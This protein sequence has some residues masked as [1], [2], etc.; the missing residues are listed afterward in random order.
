[1]EARL[2]ET[3]IKETIPLWLAVAITVVVS[4]PFG[5]YLDKYNLP[6]WV[7]FVV[8]AQYFALGAKPQALRLIVPAFVLGVAVT[9]VIMVAVAVLAP[10]LPQ[11]W[12]L[13]ICLFVGIGAMV[14]GMRYSKTLQEGSLPYFNGIS[15]LLGVYLTGAYPTSAFTT[16]AYLLPLVAAVWA[17]LGGLLGAALGWFNVT[18]TFPRQV[19]SGQQA[20]VGGHAA[21][22]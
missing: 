19:S 18:I 8:W 13:A 15:M 9:G 2:V 20:L 21:K 3:K 16:D 1:M 11:N 4:L 17:I 6:L 5:L 12:A 7:A 14:Y 10:S 22:P